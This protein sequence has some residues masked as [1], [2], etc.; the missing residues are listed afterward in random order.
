MLTS[1][2]LDE[3]DRCAYLAEDLAGR[4]ERSAIRMRDEGSYWGGFLWKYKC[5]KPK[6]ERVALD[7]E[8]AAHGLRTVA[9]GIREGWDTPERKSNK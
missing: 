5:V 3:R 7:I 6:W 4:W 2:V 9:K 1:E 8:S